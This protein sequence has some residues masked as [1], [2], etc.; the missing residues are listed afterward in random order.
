MRPE[1]ASARS[2]QPRVRPRLSSVSGIAMMG[3]FGLPLAIGACVCI[4]ATASLLAPAAGLQIRVLDE[5]ESGADPPG[6]ETAQEA[7]ESAG[8]IVHTTPQGSVRIESGRSRPPVSQRPSQDMISLGDEVVVKEDQLVI[9]DAVCILGSVRVL[10]T[11]TGDA[12]SI[13]GDVVVGPQGVIRG[14][15]VCI[16]GR[17]EESSGAQI[18]ERVQ[19][20]FLPRI[21]SSSRFFAGWSWVVFCVHLL[22]IGLGGWVTLKLSSRRWLAAIATLRER[23]GGSLLAGIGAGVVYG[24]LA[25]PLLAVIALILTVTILGL[26]LVPLVIV[27]MLLVPVPGYAVTSALLGAALR[28][29]SEGAARGADAGWV[30][31]SFFLGHLLLSLPLLVGSL[32][33]TAAARSWVGLGGVFEALAWGVILLAVAFGWG[34]LLLSRFGRRFPGESSSAASPLQPPGEGTRGAGMNGSAS[35]PG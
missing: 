16:G 32:L 25:V 12:V 33:Y 15:A 13:G 23:S 22:L 29:R 18:G 2:R 4:L 20:S 5:Q 28:G 1:F 19:I 7:E 14:Q 21:G 9:G 31:G 30:S 8:V 35:L 10:G 6:Q 26:P 11:V 27:F 24:I 3:R 17:I 34:A